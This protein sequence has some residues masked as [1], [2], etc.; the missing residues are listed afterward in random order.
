MTAPGPWND[1]PGRSVPRLGRAEGQ[2]RRWTGSAVAFRLDEFHSIGHLV[3]LADLPDEDEH[4]DDLPDALRVLVAVG[5]T[6]VR[7]VGGVESQEI[8]VLGEDHSTLR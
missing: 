5:D 2:R 8:P 3:R 1:R 4:R 7:D 6:G